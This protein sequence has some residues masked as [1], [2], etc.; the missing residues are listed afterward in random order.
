ML[1]KTELTECSNAVTKSRWPNTSGP[2]W[3]AKFETFFPYSVQ[4][5]GSSNWLDGPNL[6]DSSAAVAVTTLKVEPGMKSPCVARSR[7]G[8]GGLH[9]AWTPA[10]S[11]KCFSIRLGS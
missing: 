6:P 11:L 10:A 3:S 4:Y 5:P 2:D 8:A 9:G 7:S 1:Q